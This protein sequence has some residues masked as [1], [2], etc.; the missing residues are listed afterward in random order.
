[1]DQTPSD[2]VRT[3]IIG[4]FK[5]GVSF[6]CA[7]L[8]LHIFGQQT[9]KLINRH[10]AEVVAVAGPHRQLAVLDLTVCLLY[11]SDAADE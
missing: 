11:T 6:L 2:R 9:A 3:R 8:F 10:G 7:S 1:M 4:K 5:P